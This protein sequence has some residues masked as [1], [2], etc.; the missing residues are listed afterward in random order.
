MIRRARTRIPR[1]AK[2]RGAARPVGAILAVALVCSCTSAGSRVPPPAVVTCTD[3]DVVFARGTGQPPGFGRVG[4]PFLRALIAD[5]PARSVGAY[6][7][8]YP[9]DRQQNFGP[10]TSDIVRHVTTVARSCPATRFVLGGYSQGALAVAG[11]IGVPVVGAPA[12]R[13]PAALGPRVAAVV[14]FGSPLGARSGSL[15]SAG[16]TFAPQSVDFCNSDDS[17]CGSRGPLA[18]SH[19]SYPD[20]GSTDQAATFAVKRLTV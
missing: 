13:L 14:V 4:E 8:D 1:A 2:I 7:V 3:V 19:R 6:A 16:G 17:V 20:N 9:A 15:D 18:G 10:G 12:E 11:A 5:L